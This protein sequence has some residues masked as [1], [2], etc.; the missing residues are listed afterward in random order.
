MEKGHFAFA[1][2]VYARSKVDFAR[3][4]DS[5]SLLGHLLLFAK[6]YAH[7]LQ[8]VAHVLKLDGLP[9]SVFFEIAT[10]SGSSLT[11]LQTAAHYFEYEGGAS[12]A[13]SLL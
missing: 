7:I 12:M 6:K 9:G 8:A 5:S 3:K 11:A 2:W 10:I 4:K 1:S 13:G